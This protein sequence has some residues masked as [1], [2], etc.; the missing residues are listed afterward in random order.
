MPAISVSAPGKIILCGEHAVVYDQ[1]AIAIPVLTLCTTTNIFAHPTQPKGEILVKADALRLAEKLD[2][3]PVDDPIRKTVE[4][5]KTYFSLESLP[6]C[7]IH[8]ISTLPVAAGMGSSASLSIS[9]IRAISEFIGHPLPLDQINALAFEAEKNYHAHPSGVDN[10][11]IT[12]EK[13][14]YF[15]KGCPPEFLHIETSFQFIVA[16]TGITASTSEAVSG[17]RKHWQNDP[18]KYTTLFTQIGQISQHV[19]KNLALGN[20]KE[21]GE[22]LTL[23][24]RYLVE[25]GV[26]CSELD[27]F[28][29]V[30]INS[31][32][33]GAKLSGG[34]LGG[35]MVTLVT[36]DTTKK[37]EEA[38]GKAGAKMILK[39]TLPASAEGK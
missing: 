21:V 39:I 20:Q 18:E 9:I 8:I 37:V 1:P 30:S 17:V 26:S 34:G 32:A 14:I 7:E 11:V 25:L 15:Q 2:I 24:H 16:N 4:S 6:A 28:V 36:S 29:E 35:N 23:N 3:L 38:L 12:Y 33:L 10:T 27:R 31:G 22:L 5:V 19:R 13:P